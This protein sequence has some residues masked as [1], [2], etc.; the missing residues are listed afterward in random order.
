[1]RTIYLSAGHS[2]VKNR[3]RGAEGNGFIEGVEAAKIRQRV[4]QILKSKHNVTAVVDVDDSILSQ[5]L[6]F[7]RNKTTNKC[8]VVDIHFNAASPKA[9]GTE[10]LVGSNPT[11]F[12]LDLAFCLSDIAH[13]RLNI[14]KRGNFKGRQG[15]KSEAESHHGRLGWMRLTGENV[16]IE[17]CFIS[18]K[19]DMDAYQRE[20]ENYCSDLASVLYKFAKDEHILS[21]QSTYTVKI[22]DTLWGIS[23]SQKISVVDLRTLN[24]LKNDTL[25]VGQVLKI[26]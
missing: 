5:T 17:L 8:I 13:R 26:K 11:Q 2:T 10:T 12:E 16:L 19:S 18:N 21:T 24:N 25:K 4:A 23:Q 14:P 7:F 3:D 22:G 9:T 1:M 20:F 6:A 15:V